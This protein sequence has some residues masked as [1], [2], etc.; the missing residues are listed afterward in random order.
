MG[1]QKLFG[2]QTNKTFG[3][4]HIKCNRCDEVF[5]QINELKCHNLS[6]HLCRNHNT[7][8]RMS[9]NPDKKYEFKSKD[10]NITRLKSIYNCSQVEEE[11][12]FLKKIIDL[13]AI[14]DITF[15]SSIK[16]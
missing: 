7:N 13:S 5:T 3:S 14:K 4:I 8:K 12:E 10:K 1:E 15:P 2:T 9:S 11:R 6:T 16:L